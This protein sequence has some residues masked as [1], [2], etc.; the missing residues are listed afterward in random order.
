MI[1]PRYSQSDRVARVSQAFVHL[2]ARQV[3]RL[4]REVYPAGSDP[5]G[6]G[7][8]YGRSPVVIGY[9]A[10]VTGA[11]SPAS[12]TVYGTGTVQVYYPA[13][14]GD[15]SLTEDADNPS[16]PVNNWYTTS[17]TIAVG[18]HC[19]VLSMNGALWL[20]EFDC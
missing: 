14:A 12:G 16:V 1:R 6:M 4:R 5:R 2:V 15:P 20:L 19:M 11:I 8:Q 17:G 13:N 18:K 9:T 7:L 3:M 10:V